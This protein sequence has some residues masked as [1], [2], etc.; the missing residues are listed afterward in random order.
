MMADV[1]RCLQM[2]EDENKWRPMK[3]NEGFEIR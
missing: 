3:A 2:K 1:G